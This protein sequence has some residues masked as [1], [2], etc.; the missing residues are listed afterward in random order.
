[1]FIASDIAD[2]PSKIT[3]SWNFILTPR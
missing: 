1:L 3:I 2:E